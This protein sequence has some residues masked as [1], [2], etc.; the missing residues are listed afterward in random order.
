MSVS[1]STLFSSRLAY[2]FLVR[3]CTSRRDAINV[4][5]VVVVVV[6]VIDVMIIPSLFPFSPT[7]I[8]P[9][10]LIVYGKVYVN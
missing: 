8:F 1:F 6:V 7:P 5:V 3:C 10:L 2:G 9:F 4:A